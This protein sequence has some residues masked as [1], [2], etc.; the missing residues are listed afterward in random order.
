MFYSFFR[1]LVFIKIPVYH[2][3][4]AIYDGQTNEVTGKVLH[5]AAPVK[6]NDSTSLPTIL[7]FKTRSAMSSDLFRKA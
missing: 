7:M 1:V 6:S 4:K 5:P 2:K 3:R